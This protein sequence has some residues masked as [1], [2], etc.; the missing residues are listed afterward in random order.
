[1]AGIIPGILEVV[2]YVA[3]IYL[4][5]LI[6]PSMGP[7]GESFKFKEKVISLKYTWPVIILFLLVIGGIYG[8]IF[9]PTEA[10]A[11]GAF[12]AMIITVGMRRLN[13]HGLLSCL[14]QALQTTA[15]I[16]VLVVG[17]FIFANFMAKSKLPFVFGDLV[18]GLTV[19][20]YLILA[21]IIFI[22]IILGM[23]LDIFSSILLT[24]P[25]IFPAVIA[26]GF[27][28]IWFG[29]IMVRVMEIGLITPPIGMNV[30][31]LAGVTDIPLGTIFKGIVPFVIAD[32]FH[33]AL[34]VAVP[35][36][37]LF[38]PNAMF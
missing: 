6:S 29:V 18:T 1:M 26:M 33:V 13:G 8:G 23:F 31:I 17:A 12:G 7:K 10:G 28:P 32:I 3:T 25:I 21:A 2:F 38:L 16:I 24:I 19:S 11:V 34:L 9:T 30:F 35:R 20:K 27:D 37:S 22:Y 14:T 36:L 15:M 5:C 4:M